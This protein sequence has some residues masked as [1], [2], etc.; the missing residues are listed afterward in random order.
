MLPCV[1]EYWLRNS[2]FVDPGCELK[3]RQW[4][5]FI[6]EI[7]RIKKVVVTG[8]K[9]KWNPDPESKSGVSLARNGYLE[10]LEIEDVVATETSLRF[11]VKRRLEVLTK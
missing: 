11:R 4:P 2:I 7:I 1:H 3:E 9:V 5:K 6:N 10:V 8:S